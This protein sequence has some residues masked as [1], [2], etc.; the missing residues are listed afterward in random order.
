MGKKKVAIVGYTGSLGKA[1]TKVIDYDYGFNTK[2]INLFD[3]ELYQKFPVDIDTI[4]F[5]AA[6]PKIYYYSTKPEECFRNNYELIK[7]ILKCNYRK[8]I[9]VSTVCVYKQLDNYSNN[10][11]TGWNTESNFYGIAKLLAE[12]ELIEMARNYCI[13]RMSTPYSNNMS[14]GPLFDILTY[15]QSFVDMDSRYS[16]IHVEDASLAIKYCFENDLIGIYN[17][18]DRKST[19]LKDIFG[20]KK[21]IH[22][23]GHS[24]IDYDSDNQLLRDSGWSQKYNVVEFVTKYKTKL[25]NSD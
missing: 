25:V 17:L 6:D 19:R 2:N 11:E 1:L 9:F 21:D 23:I 13:L 7:N 22:C 5:L 20:W 15:N 4:I 12:K 3:K 18:T 24:K 14:K 8:L 16:F 10:P